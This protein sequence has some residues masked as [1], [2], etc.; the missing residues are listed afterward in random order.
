MPTLL[1]MTTS[2][3]HKID[4]KIVALND[5]LNQ[6]DIIDIVSNFNHRALRYIFLSSAH[7]IVNNTDDMLLHKV[8]SKNL[9]K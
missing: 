7:D 1:S 3:P 9:N 4:I 5:P 2:S 8:T 6:M